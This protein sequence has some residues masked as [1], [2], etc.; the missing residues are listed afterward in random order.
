[1]DASFK[2]KTSK[3]KEISINSILISDIDG[4]IKNETGIKEKSIK[5]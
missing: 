3:I 1:M 4:P 2:Y 5:K